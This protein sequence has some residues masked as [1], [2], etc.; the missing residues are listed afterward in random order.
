MVRKD[1]P[2][3]V[4]SLAAHAGLL[5]LL[6]LWRLPPEP[7][8]PPRRVLLEF[9]RPAPLRPPERPPAAGL[10]AG[11]QRAVPGLQVSEGGRLATPPAAVPAARKTIP[12]PEIPRR[13][14]DS[15]ARVP[16]ATAAAALPS[17]EELLRG[18]AADR[19]APA[20]AG[21]T[22]G[23]AP[24]GYLQTTALE[25]KAGERILLQ[26][27]RLDFPEL[28]LEKGLEVDVEAAFV[29]APNGQVVRVEITRSSGFASVDRE[30]EQALRDALFAES[31]REDTG[32]I[33]F[34]FRLERKQ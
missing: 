25:W 2:F 24:A 9:R 18:L 10:P 15:P 3:L 5:L 17:A 28:L 14:P 22:A 23:A 4:F 31:S 27:P 1:L 32:R 33:Q 11:P 34:R 12:L 30:V 16:E 20:A 13:L 8:V 7:E 21:G 19:A 6:L 29:V 26:Q